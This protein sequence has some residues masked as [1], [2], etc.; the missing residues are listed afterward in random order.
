MASAMPPESGVRGASEAPLT[1]RRTRGSP[2]RLLRAP[3]SS[4]GLS[5]DVESSGEVL[6]VPENSGE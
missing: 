6:T 3:Q 5:K 4:E 1:A 2:G